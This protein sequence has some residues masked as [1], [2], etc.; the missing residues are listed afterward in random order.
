MSGL[1]NIDLVV[2]LVVARTFL[3]PLARAVVLTAAL[4][5][6]LRG[7]SAAERPALLNAS[8]RVLVSLLPVA[9]GGSCLWPKRRSRG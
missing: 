9:P 8:A 3:A 1:Y 2:G 5:L 7:S 6:V 4:A